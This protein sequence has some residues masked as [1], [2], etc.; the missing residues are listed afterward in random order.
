MSRA[1]GGRRLVELALGGDPVAWFGPD[2]PVWGDDLVVDDALRGVV[3]AEEVLVFVV[4]W[5]VAG[6]VWVTGLEPTGALRGGSDSARFGSGA[7]AIVLVPPPSTSESGCALANYY[8]VSI[9]PPSNGA[10]DR[11]DPAVDPLQSPI[12]D[13][14]ETPVVTSS[15][16]GTS[17]ADEV[18]HASPKR[19]RRALI[20]NIAIG[21]AAL[22]FWHG[23][24]NV[25]L[26]YYQFGPG[27]PRDTLQLVTVQGA[28]TF[29]TDGQLFLTTV[30]ARTMTPAL[31]IQTWLDSDL[32]AE[33]IKNIRG[34]T[35]QTDFDKLNSFF[36]VDSQQT[37]KVVALRRLGFEV[38]SEIRGALVAGVEPNTPAAL[39]L[40]AGDTI[41][42]VNGVEIVTQEQLREQIQLVT[43]GQSVSV[44]YVTYGLDGKEVERTS[45]IG[46]YAADDGKVRIGILALPDLRYDFPVDVT[47]ATS[48]IGGPSAGLAFTLSIIDTMTEGFLTG[49]MDVACTGTIEATGQVGE[50]GGVD[51]K[52]VAVRAAKA[53]LFLVPT[54]EV[55]I[56]RGVLGDRVEVVGVDTL[57][58]A[59]NALL[60]RKGEAKGLK[61]A[62]SVVLLPDSERQYVPHG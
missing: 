60:A 14:V 36:M 37:A 56:A 9:P 43:P 22:A 48:N 23:M 62:D 8:V 49:G 31:A 41:L 40:A 26:D 53:D 6:R 47:I 38:P 51:D 54:S 4:C 27:R 3:P 30:T 21:L 50:V 61:P 33:K 42:A 19:R 7:P 29:P 18:D 13:I 34:E 39:V 11:V 58:D 15:H 52:A 5:L 59:I 28:P 25:T 12:D 55:D 2:C 32:H 16:D 24:F 57:E 46:T 20:I 45:D 44:R 10:V 17:S 1:A 35:S